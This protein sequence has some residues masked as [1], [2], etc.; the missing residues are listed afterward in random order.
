MIYLFFP[1]A[2]IASLPQLFPG[3]ILGHILVLTSLKHH[4]R[5]PKKCLSLL[6]SDSCRRNGKTTG[7]LLLLKLLFHSIYVNWS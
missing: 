7:I 5:D 4:Q 3:W 6:F 1:S 2:S